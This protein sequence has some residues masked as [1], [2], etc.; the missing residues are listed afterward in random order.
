MRKRLL[1][2]ALI[3]LLSAGI[4]TILYWDQSRRLRQQIQ[5]QG[6]QIEERL[7]DYVDDRLGDLSATLLDKD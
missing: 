7:E 2:L 6:D 4:G 1:D 5:R 3:A